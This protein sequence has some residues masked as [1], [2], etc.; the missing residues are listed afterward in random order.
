MSQLTHIYLAL[1][2]ILYWSSDLHTQ[3]ERAYDLSLKKELIYS[4]AG[5]A[6][7][8]LGVY[9]KSKTPTLK[10]SDLDL[11]DIGRF[12]RIATRFDSD[13]AARFSDWTLNCSTALPLLF[14]VDQKTK[15]QFGS[16]LVLFG[17]TM[18]ANQGF[19]DLIKSISLR[20]RPYVYSLDPSTTLSKNDR[21]SFLSG[22]TSGTA[23]AS[24]FVARVFTGFYPDS[25]LK[26]Y[27]WVLASALPALTG[28]L[29]I[30]AG[31]HYPTDVIAG[32]ALGAA[33]GNLI[34]L[35]HK[36][37]KKEKRLTMATFAGGLY[38]NYQF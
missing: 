14:L 36:S 34:P 28:Y 38:M 20:P 13:R 30:R 21:A 15:Q 31:R 17:E 1:L 32:Y 26:P 35:L 2:L 11:D 25:K 37:R 24:F 9:L 27:V 4:G 16:I 18:L 10:I 23:A 8:S 12:D 5:A 6:I 3:T 7:F 19:T 33:A 29:R 22:H